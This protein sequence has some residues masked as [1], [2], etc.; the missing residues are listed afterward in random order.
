[1]RPAMFLRTWL[2]FLLGWYLLAC[3]GCC[4]Q[5]L[6]DCARA[7]A[8]TQSSYT[9]HQKHFTHTWRFCSGWFPV[10]VVFRVQLCLCSCCGGLRPRQSCCVQGFQVSSGGLFQSSCGHFIKSQVISQIIFVLILSL[11]CECSVYEF[12]VK[13]LIGLLILNFQPLWSGCEEVAPLV[14]YLQSPAVC[15]LGTSAPPSLHPREIFQLNKKS[16]S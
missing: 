12:G 7:Y 14:C 15:P 5:S 13:L 10:E 4:S 2:F 1:M 6:E 3:L 8:L 16:A 9:T 11:I